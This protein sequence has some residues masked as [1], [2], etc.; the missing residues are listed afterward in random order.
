MTFGT[1]SLLLLEKCWWIFLICQSRL[2]GGGLERKNV[3]TDF[4]DY[5]D[6]CGGDFLLVVLL[7]LMK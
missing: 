3:T 1:A 6:F 4:T 7:F 5:A 2:L